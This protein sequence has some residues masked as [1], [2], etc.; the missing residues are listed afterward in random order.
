MNFP[1]SE[2]CYENRKVQKKRPKT[3]VLDPGVAEKYM[4]VVQYMFI[5]SNIVNMEYQHI[6]GLG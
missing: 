5:D 2:F 4:S 1:I 3:L 6:Q